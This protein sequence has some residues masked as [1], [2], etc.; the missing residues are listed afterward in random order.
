MH[1]PCRADEPLAP[2]EA[3][4]TTARQ[5]TMTPDEW[6]ER[7][8]FWREYEVWQRNPEFGHLPGQQRLF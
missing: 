5:S 1:G 3:C 4:M 8:I 6:A 2:S 7:L